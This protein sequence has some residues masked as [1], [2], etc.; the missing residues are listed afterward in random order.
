MLRADAEQCWL[1]REV[2]PVLREV[3]TPE[4]LLEEEVGAALAYLE[5]MWNEATLRARETDAAHG[6][7]CSRNG[8]SEV[9]SGPARRYHAAVRALRGILADRVTP[10]VDPSLEFDGRS[11]G[12]SL[13]G[14]R[15]T[16]KRPD[17]CHR[18]A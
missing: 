6:N 12:V 13:G 2:I 7:L 11:P 8:V 4:E 14:L 9:L 10:F 1:H 15:V 17:G 18:A 3:E 16:D 5:A